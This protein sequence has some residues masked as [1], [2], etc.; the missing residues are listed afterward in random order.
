MAWASN[1]NL[2]VEEDVV[3]QG[4]MSQAT[5]TAILSEVCEEMISNGGFEDEGSWEIPGTAYSASYTTAAARSDDR[6]MRVGIVEQGDN[7]YGYSSAR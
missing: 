3:D 6:S 4:W 5:D 1:S 7:V 2:F